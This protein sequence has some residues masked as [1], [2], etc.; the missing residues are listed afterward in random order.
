MNMQNKL[1]TIKFFSP[2]DDHFTARPQ[3]AIA[4]PQTHNFCKIPKKNP[5]LPKKFKL[6]DKRGF[7]L[8]EMRKKERKS[9]GPPITPIHKLNLTPMVWN[10]SIGQL[11]MAA[12]LCCLPAPAHLLLS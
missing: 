10:I 3:A 6:P 7:T 5:K 12:W 1:Y 8:M 4:E 9:P 11:G 2:P